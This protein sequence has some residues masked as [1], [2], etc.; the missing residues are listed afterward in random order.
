M[1]AGVGI[2]LRS[3]IRSIDRAHEQPLGLELPVRGNSVK[4]YG[5]SEARSPDSLPHKRASAAA[6]PLSPILGSFFGLGVSHGYSPSPASVLILMM[7]FSLPWSSTAPTDLI[8]QLWT[9]S[10]RTNLAV[11]QLVTVESIRPFLPPQLTRLAS[12][13]SGWQRDQTTGQEQ[14]KQYMAT[15]HRQLLVV[16]QSIEPRPTC[17]RR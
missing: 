5:D 17:R 16:G 10:L 8:T 12:D 9:R 6:L 13:G 14:C 1:V 15:L 4:R 3:E 7:V 11:V 2:R